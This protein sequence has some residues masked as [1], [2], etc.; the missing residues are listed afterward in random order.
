ML[1]FGGGHCSLAPSP[2]FPCLNALTETRGARKFTV[3]FDA[4]PNRWVYFLLCFSFTRFLATTTARVFFLT[5]ER[6]CL[7]HVTHRTRSSRQYQLQVCVR[8]A[9]YTATAGGRA[10]R[11]LLIRAGGDLPVLYYCCNA[12]Q[13]TRTISTRC[14]LSIS[15]VCTTTI[16]RGLIFFFF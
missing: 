12:V 1:S 15:L 2:S 9:S 4:R 11:T 16:I 5:T 7:D 6:L 3:A 10:V 14:I 13:Y 8:A